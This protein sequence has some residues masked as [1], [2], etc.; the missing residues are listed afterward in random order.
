MGTQGTAAMA[1][2]PICS[3]QASARTHPGNVVQHVLPLH[4][5]AHFHQPCKGPMGL[6]AEGICS[7]GCLQPL[8]AVGHIQLLP[9]A[10]LVHAAGAHCSRG[11]GGNQWTGQL[12]SKWLM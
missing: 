1:Y 2:K 10:R 9:T 7:R 5:G 3:S 8:L 11:S 4:C 6:P 12:C